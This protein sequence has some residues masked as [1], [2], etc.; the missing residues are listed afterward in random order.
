MAKIAA[1]L[2]DE[3]KSKLAEI[4]AKDAESTDSKEKKSAKTYVCYEFIY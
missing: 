4:S 3:Q 2:S 1:A